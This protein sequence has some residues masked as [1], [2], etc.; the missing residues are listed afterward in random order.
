MHTIYLQITESAD[1][2]K[3][4]R[5]GKNRFIEDVEGGSDE[6][7]IV[8]VE[9]GGAEDGVKGGTGREGGEIELRGVG[10]MNGER[11]VR[12]NG[13]KRTGNYGKM[14]KS[15]LPFRQRVVNDTKVILF[16]LIFFCFL[17]SCFVD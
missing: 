13:S 15:V 16:Y 6:G 3:R 11:S 12:E 2:S 10:S 1:S 17:L 14:S 4:S 7:L 9:K 8:T 5:N